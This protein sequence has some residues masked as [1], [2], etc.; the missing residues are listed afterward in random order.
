VLNTGKIKTFGKNG[1]KIIGRS[2]I[3]IGEDLGQVIIIKTIERR[4]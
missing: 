4:A 2:I 3:C 1:I